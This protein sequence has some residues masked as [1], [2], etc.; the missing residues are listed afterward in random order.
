[1]R[2][3]RSRLMRRGREHPR[4]LRHARSLLAERR[5]FAKDAMEFR[6]LFQEIVHVQFV[7]LAAWRLVLAK[8]QNPSLAF[9]V[10]V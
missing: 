10:P 3:E 4:G 7:G 6:L 5:F 8:P 1:M 9:S 2:R